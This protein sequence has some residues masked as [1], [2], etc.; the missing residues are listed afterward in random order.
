[1][2]APDGD[3]ENGTTAEPGAALAP[4]PSRLGCTV[5]ALLAL[6]LAAVLSLALALALLG[7]DAGG[8][9]ARAVLERWASS[10]AGG[11][12]RI[13][14]LDLHPWRAE[15]TATAVSLRR[16][17][18]SVD[19]GRIDAAWSPGAGVSVRL[20][21]PVVVVQD[22]GEPEPEETRATGLAAQPWRLLETLGRAE[23][24]EGR[25]EMRDRAGAPWLVLGRVD[26]ETRPGSR[27]G[28]RIADAA[29]GWPAGGLRLNPAVAEAKL[30]LDEGGLVV[31]EARVATGSSSLELHGRLDRLAPIRANATARIVF[32]GDLVAALA[33]GTEIAGRIDAHASVDLA[34]DRL[35]GSLDATAPALT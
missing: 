33:P 11:P 34:D 32:D 3:Q 14:D 7:T 23:V 8:A 17:G 28:V 24:I 21:R 35:M 25:V 18:T 5:R 27:I 12:V 2:S 30:S 4:R 31:E 26:A 20:E 6:S 15:A 29:V 1:M 9:A 13:G 10:A 22:T 19:V 16:P